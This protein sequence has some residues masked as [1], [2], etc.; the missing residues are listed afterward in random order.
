MVLNK[1]ESDWQKSLA[2]YILE[3][4]VEAYLNYL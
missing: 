3:A 4:E 2:A 1:M